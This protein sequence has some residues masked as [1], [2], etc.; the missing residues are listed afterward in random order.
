VS[1]DRDTSRMA[2]AT[3]FGA[4]SLGSHGGAGG[5]RA[6]GGA[7]SSGSHGGSAF[8]TLPRKSGWATTPGAIGSWAGEDSG[9]GFGLSLGTETS[10]GI[11]LMGTD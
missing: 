8:M 11:S 3:Q 4:D 2:P 1:S 7:I 6:N 10:S 9:A 5:S